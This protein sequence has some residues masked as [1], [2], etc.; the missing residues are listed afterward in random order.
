MRWRIY[1]FHNTLVS[2]TSHSTITKTS[3]FSSYY[4]NMRLIQEKQELGIDD[5]SKIWVI[6][7]ISLKGP[8]RPLKAKSTDIGDGEITSPTTRRSIAR[9]LVCPPAP[10]KAK[11]S[12][13]CRIDGI[14]FFSVPEDLESVFV[15]RG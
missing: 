14:E 10:K 12:L 5:D 13:M 9:R 1:P 3:T 11:P 6:S 8:L 2:L 15:G 7:G 4:S